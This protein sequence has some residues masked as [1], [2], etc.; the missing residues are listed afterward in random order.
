M[1]ALVAISVA[2]IPIAGEVA[3][4]VKPIEMSMTNDAGMP[5]CPC[6]DDQDNSKSSVACVLK[7]INFVGAVVPTMILTQPYLVDAGP[8]SF[9]VGI[10]HGHVRSPPTHPPPV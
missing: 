9:V 4:S 3:V 5:C 2:V 6:C 7:C 1:A 10:L 8:P